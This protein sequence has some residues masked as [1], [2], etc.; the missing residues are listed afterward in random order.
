MI[1]RPGPALDFLWV[2]CVSFAVALAAWTGLAW[3]LFGE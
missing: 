3:W 1:V 2:F